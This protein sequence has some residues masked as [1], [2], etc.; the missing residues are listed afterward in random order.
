MYL[1]DQR[2]Q[3]GFGFPMRH[4]FVLSI[5]NKRIIVNGNCDILSILILYIC[6]S[7]LSVLIYKK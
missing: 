5:E 7:S 4:S 1:H 3:D 6:K 2:Q